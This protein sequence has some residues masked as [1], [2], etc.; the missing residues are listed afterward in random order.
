MPKQVMFVWIV[1]K[2]MTAVYCM[3]ASKCTRQSTERGK[4]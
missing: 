1:K 3:K 4:P 2:D